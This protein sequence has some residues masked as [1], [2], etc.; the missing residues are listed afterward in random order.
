VATTAGLL[1]VASGLLAELSH[2][3]VLAFLTLSYAAWGAGL[4]QNLKANW[5]LL[6]AT[7]TSTNLLS[8]AAFDLAMR[9]SGRA[10]PRRAAASVAY[11][12]SELAKEAPYYAGALG[13][14]LVTESVAAGDAIVFLAGANLGAAAY[15]YG[16]ARLVRTMLQ[17]SEHGRLRLI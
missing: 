16:L 1:L 14:A 12:G 15:E 8:K 6:E 2:E 13:L 5:A 11:A 3:T 7:G 9:R 17:R 4:W 10:G